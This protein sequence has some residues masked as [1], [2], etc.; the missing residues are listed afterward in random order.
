M[1]SDEDKA[2]HSERRK[3]NMIAKSLWSKETNLRPKRVELKQE[4]NP[5]INLSNYRRFILDGDEDS[6]DS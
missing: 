5:K 6:T 1:G 2:R 4:D 3:R